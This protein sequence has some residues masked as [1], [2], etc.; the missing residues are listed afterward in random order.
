VDPSTLLRPVGHEPARV[1][2]VRRAIVLLAV[3]VVVA[4]VAYA[5]GGGS[6]RPSRVAA[7]H[8]TPT[9]STTSPRAAV[10]PRCG[11]QTL[12]VIA[13][14][15]A[16]TYPTGASPRLSVSVRNTGT[17]PCLLATQPGARI[18]SIFSGADQV[19]TTSA[20][21]RSTTLAVSRLRPGHGVSYALVWDRHRS[22][23]GCAGAGAEAQPGTY[24]LY[25]GVDGV[26]SAPVVFHLTH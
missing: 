9:P 19:W 15:D 3:V 10:V 21:Q 26:R 4:L 23:S 12:A 5:C 25:V 13:R 7:T 14:T 17:G 1:Y 6:T 16:L 11:T 20:C 18:W 22:V 8:P 24:R 2:W